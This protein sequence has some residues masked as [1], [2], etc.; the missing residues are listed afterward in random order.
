MPKKHVKK[1]KK[2]RGKGAVSDAIKFAREH[3]LLSKGLGLIPNPAAQAA[4]TVA[5]FLG[6]GRQCGRG[7]FGDIGSGIGS[8]AH[9]FF[10]SGARPVPQ[11]M[12]LP[13]VAL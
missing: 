5:G 13:V 9:G 10:G 7:I 8:I 2:Q 1:G 11:F 6:F 12:R 3:K 4:A